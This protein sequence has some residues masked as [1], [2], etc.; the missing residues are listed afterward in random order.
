ML[1]LKKISRAVPQ[2][3]KQAFC[4]LTKGLYKRRS[5]DLITNHIYQ[6]FEQT[7]TRH[8][9]KREL[10]PMQ[11]IY[12]SRRSRIRP[13]QTQNVFFFCFVFF[14]LFVCL[15]FFFFDRSNCL[16]YAIKGNSKSIIQNVSDL[17][18][19][20]CQYYAK[21]NLSFIIY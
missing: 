18:K 7:Q 1:P 5:S 9:H 16:E 17:T 15:F 20:L 3:S 10:I 2:S 12:L 21:C 4:F 14:C 8:N 13:Q 19:C 11:I 6:S